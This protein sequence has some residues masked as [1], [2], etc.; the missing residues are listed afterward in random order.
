MAR[1]VLTLDDKV[2]R[3]LVL[4]K[5]R[6]T[7][8]RGPHNDLVIDSLAVSAEHAAIA[9]VDGDV[10]LEDLNSTNGTQVNGQPVKMHF[11]Q[12]GD[13]IELAQY[14]IGYVADSDGM[15]SLKTPVIRV[16]NGANAG[17]KTLLTKTLT[18][19]GRPGVQVALV[20]Q[21][22]GGFYLTH[23]EGNSYP[24]VNGVAIAAQEYKLRHRDIIDLS[25]TQLEFLL[26]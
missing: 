8:G 21:R 20:T 7:I 3:E 9:T 6:L 17:K 25:G 13:V 1:I 14:R 2:L 10:V 23:V 16:L 12:D 24:L 4:S 5:E 26:N 18:T 15:Q 22:N 19:I 11:L